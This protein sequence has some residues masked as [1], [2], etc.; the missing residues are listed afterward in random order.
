MV[1]HKVTDLGHMAQNTKN[2]DFFGP[3]FSTLNVFISE[4]KALLTSTVIL[5]SYVSVK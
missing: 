2:P 4:S 1:L 5:I 3:F